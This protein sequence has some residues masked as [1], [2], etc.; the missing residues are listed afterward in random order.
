[1]KEPV[2]VLREVVL[3]LHDVLLAEFGGPSGIRDEALLDSALARPQQMFHY[4]NPDLFTLA[5]AYIYGI[6]KNHPFVDGNKRTAFMT[7][8]VFLARNGKTLNAPE[9]ETT[10]AILD[11]TAGKM[12]EA[13]FTL[14]LKNN[15]GLK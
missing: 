6:L 10:R 15:C 5:T 3:T 14:W 11:L 7:A 13:E 8:F 12:T 1:M 2:W 4:E 9:A